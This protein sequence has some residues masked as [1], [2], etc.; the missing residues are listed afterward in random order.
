MFALKFIIDL[1]NGEKKRNTIVRYAVKR[2]RS[3]FVVAI[4]VLLL[5]CKQIL[6]IIVLTL[7]V[8]VKV[9]PRGSLRCSR[10][11]LKRSSRI[12]LMQET[13]LSIPFIIKM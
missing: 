13:K 2:C 12:V 1:Q 4:S 7:Y 8:E 10:Y 11:I 5:L 6:V 9:F 3:D